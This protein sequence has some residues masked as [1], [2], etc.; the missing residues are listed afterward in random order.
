MS[1][2]RTTAALSP[3]SSLGTA[4]GAPMLEVFC[5]TGMN[6]VEEAFLPVHSLRRSRK[7]HDETWLSQALK[8]GNLA[9]PEGPRMQF[10]NADLACVHIEPHAWL[11]TGM[12]DL[13][14]TGRGWLHTEL[15][16]RFCVFR[17]RGERAADV[18]AA[19]ANLHGVLPGM[20]CR[21]SFAETTTVV[22]Q[23]FAAN[24]YRLIGDVS[25]GSFL[26]A[27][28]SDAGQNLAPVKEQVP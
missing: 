22:V 18:L 3:R 5:G 14:P 23:C 16:Q 1:S 19:G 12:V 21:M 24:D 27:W 9:I 4:G 28:L 26:A 15:S 7:T 2:D 10:G 17:L 6:I 8:S 13:P 20:G 25:L 11:I